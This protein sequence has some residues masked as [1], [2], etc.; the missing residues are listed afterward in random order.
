MQPI[1][2]PLRRRPLVGCFRSLLLL[3]PVLL[4]V[5]SPTNAQLVEQAILTAADGQLGDQL[6]NRVAIDDGVVVAGAWYED[7]ACPANVRCNSGAAYVFEFTDEHGWQQAAKLTAPDAAEDAYF[8][9]SVAISGTT[10][11]VG[12]YNDQEFGLLSGAAYVF[13]RDNPECGAWGLVAK[14]LPPDPAE[15][16][17]FGHAVSIDGDYIVV[18]AHGDSSIC[19]EPCLAGAAYVF[20]KQN[21]LWQYQ[22][23]LTPHDPAEFKIFGKSVDLDKT[24]LIVAAPRDDEAAFQVGAV[25]VFERDG[26]TFQ[27]TKKLVPPTQEIDDEGLIGWWPGGVS[28]DAGRVLAGAWA[29]KSTCVLP[30]EVGCG[31]AFLF[32]QTTNGTWFFDELFTA[33]EPTEKGYYGA[34]A[35]IDGNLHAIGQIGS[36][37]LGFVHVR[38]LQANSWIDQGELLPSDFPGGEQSW[39]FGASVALDDGFL[40]VGA[41]LADHGCLEDP[42]CDS[43]SV[44]IFGPQDEN[45]PATT[46]C[47]APNPDPTCVADDTS[48]C[49]LEDRF[50]VE[51]SWAD[52]AG[53]TGSGHAAPERTA[54]SG[55]FWFFGESNWEVLV[56]MVDACDFNDRFWFF[57]AATTNVGYTI[58]VTDTQTNTVTTYSNPLGVAS[59]AV[60]DTDAFAT[61]SLEP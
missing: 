8:G 17:E 60:T 35:T 25:Y 45:P 29:N 13:E 44:Y 55:L 51:V 57:A 52:F 28:V 33:Q 12:A 34:A 22:E 26:G 16:K 38:E 27:E 42:N 21:G 36:S 5:G 40:A 15:F 24:T 47:I 9:Y 4:V 46:T 58:T 3:P 54:D 14:L 18:G 39:A 41:V 23:K 31:G 1:P 37:F 30:D 19:D 59:P 43:G 32:K 6:G 49:L 7:S 56:K 50:R 10:A 48:V 20:K 2:R 53:G 61:C 11:V